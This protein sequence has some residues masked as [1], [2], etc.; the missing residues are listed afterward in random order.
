EWQK[1]AVGVVA[2]FISIAF[3]AMGTY[4]E[5]YKHLH[6]VLFPE[7]HQG[8]RDDLISFIV[9]AMAITA[10]L[11]ILQWQSLFP[12]LR[13]Y[14]AL[15]GLPIRPREI[16][17]AKFGALI[18]I[19]TIFVASMTVAPAILFSTLI[20]GHWQENPHPL[21]YVAANVAALGGGCVFVFFTLLAIQGILLHLFSAH[22]FAR[23]S[24]AV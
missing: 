4:R 7:Y 3:A 2:A 21:M 8:V 19:F 9:L 12:S 23:V 5:R 18:V 11:T 16:F 24:L 10:L 17:L 22:T 20:T 1:V 14:L 6:A 15:A 13:D